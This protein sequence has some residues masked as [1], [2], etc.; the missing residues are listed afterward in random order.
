ME[1]KFPKPCTPIKFALEQIPADQAD[2]RTKAARTKFAEVCA[3]MN[4]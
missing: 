4:K 3:Y 1:K 2:D